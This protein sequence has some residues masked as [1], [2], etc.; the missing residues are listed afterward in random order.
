MSADMDA[1]MQHWRLWQLLDSSFP[2][3]GF[4][5]SGGV[6]A[7]ARAGLLPPG[8]SQVLEEHIAAAL[9]S[10][11]SL[12][13]PFLLAAHGGSDAAALSATLD[14]HLVASPV[15]RRASAA[16]GAALLRAA[17]GAF[18]N[19]A[20][21]PLEQLRVR[22]ARTHTLLHGAVVLGVLSAALRLPAATAARA[23]LFLLLRDACSAA[24]RLGVLGPMA[25]SAMQARCAARAEAMLA[26]A[27]AQDCDVENAAGGNP[28]ADTLQAGHDALF[29]RLFQS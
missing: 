20:A 3:G 7:S 24:T 16:A 4:A 9:A 29:A 11:C 17:A 6:E 27:M 19:A 13:L 26:E 14:L 22:A 2:T 12:A 25:A 8:D 10:S 15:A 21:A 28:F 5:H 18:P 1:G 23:H